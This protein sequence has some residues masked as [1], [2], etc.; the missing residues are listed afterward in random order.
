MSEAQFLCQRGASGLSCADTDDS[1][2]QFALVQNWAA[3]TTEVWAKE[4]QQEIRR[5]K[6]IETSLRFR[7]RKK[8]E[9]AQLRAEREYLEQEVERR[10]KP[11]WKSTA[12]REV[13]YTVPRIDEEV[14][15]A[16]CRLAVER[17]TLRTENIK[18]Q[19]KIEIF[20]HFVNQTYE[21]IQDT[22]SPKKKSSVSLSV[23]KASQT[24]PWTMRVDP[25]D[26][27][28][29]VHFPNE[30]PSFYFTPFTREEYVSKFNVCE[31]LMARELPFSS[32]KGRLFGWTVRHAPL[33]RRTADNSFFAHARFSIRVGWALED[34]DAFMN[35]APVDAIAILYVAPDGSRPQRDFVSMQVLEEFNRDSFLMVCN[36]PG[37]KH[38]RYF[39]LPRGVPGTEANGRRSISYQMVIADTEDNKLNRIAEESQHDV[40]WISEGGICMKFTQVDD[41]TIDVT[42]DHWA[43]C[44]SERHAQH[45][46]VLWAESACQWSQKVVPRN[47]LG[48]T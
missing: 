40:Q 29:R 11:F 44:E 19:Q 48:S 17:D 38:T 15:R 46:F 22:S 3:T 42:S 2:N 4:V 33:V 45:Y 28:W 39:Q 37:Q 41:T 27:G 12:N 8:K 21:A 26:S 6:R 24:A 14:V 18:F 34:A 32:I 16:V 43:I 13:N 7:A 35:A 9:L 47:L 10:V 20:E 36:I 23:R 30:E 1:T 5:Q 25:N 31:E